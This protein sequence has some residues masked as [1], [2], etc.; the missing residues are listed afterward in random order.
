MKIIKNYAYLLWYAV[1]MNIFFN[2][3]TAQ[4]WQGWVFSITL[5]LLIEWRADK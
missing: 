3:H 2:I 5:I 4:S 1:G